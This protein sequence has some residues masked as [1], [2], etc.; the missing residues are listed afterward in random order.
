MRKNK[1]T[2][3]A[4]GA[5]PAGGLKRGEGLGWLP[6]WEERPAIQGLPILPSR[7]PSP[8]TPHTHRFHCYG[9]ACLRGSSAAHRETI[10]FD[11]KLF[12]PLGCECTCS[13]CEILRQERAP[14]PLITVPREDAPCLSCGLT[15]GQKVAMIDAL[16]A[17]GRVPPVV[18]GVVETWHKAFAW[19]CHIVR[20]DET[21][22]GTAL[23]NARVY[24]VE[25]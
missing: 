20:W 21:G 8:R 4:G 9:R 14:E 11:P 25:A 6:E 5:P 16:R 23:P 7:L 2:P 22:I 10:L 19:S 3:R 1:G 17:P 15:V 24:R 13:V 18:A 12:N